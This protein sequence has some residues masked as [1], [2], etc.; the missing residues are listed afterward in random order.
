MGSAIAAAI[1]AVLGI[2]GTVASN[3]SLVDEA[4]KNRDFQEKMSNT[5]YTRA[6]ADMKNAGLNPGMMYGNSGMQASTPAGSMASGMQ[7]IFKGMEAQ[8]VLNAML[9][10]K[11]IQSI[12]AE[13]DKTNAETGNILADTEKINL[14]NSWYPA[15]SQAQL[16]SIASTIGLNT[17]VEELNKAHKIT[18]DLENEWIPRLRSAQAL[19]LD[20]STALNQV[21]KYIKDFEKRYMDEYGVRP[22]DSAIADTTAFICKQLGI[23]AT[24]AVEDIK[25]FVKEVLG[26][27]SSNIPTEFPALGLGRT[28]KAKYRWLKD[29]RDNQLTPEWRKKRF[30]IFG[31]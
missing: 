8:N 22:G 15:L 7:P 29:L 21:E 14:L 5:A 25:T 31:Y 24:D 30:E 18:A 2:V 26:I 6:V 23:S 3:A 11:Q 4:Q 17:S 27:E 12:D 10:K 19:N 20:S 13:I 16:D 1:A 9:T 28:D